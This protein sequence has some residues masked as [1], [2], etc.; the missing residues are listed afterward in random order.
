MTDARDS[1]ERSVDS[2]TSSWLQQARNGDATAWKRLDKTYRRL[3]CWWC[4]KS[5]IPAQDIDDVV[6][7]VFAA[8]A[9]ALTDFEHQSFRG[10]LWTVTRN[11]IN[12]HWRRTNQQ[13]TAKGGSSIQQILASVEAESSRSVGSVDQATKI[14][15]DAI[16]EL[17]KGEFSEQQWRAFWQSAVDGKPAAQVAEELGITRNQVYLAKSRILHRIRQEFGDEAGNGFT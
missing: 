12:D 9:K 10:F 15:F 1:I 6:Q 16:V 17:V 11:K 2:T 5:G 14:L 3:V 7:E 4:G 13:P 8:V